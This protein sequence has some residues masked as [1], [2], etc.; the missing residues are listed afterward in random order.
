MATVDIKGKY[1]P[2]NKHSMSPASMLMPHLR[3][4]QPSVDISS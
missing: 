1:K 3:D 2:S 4:V